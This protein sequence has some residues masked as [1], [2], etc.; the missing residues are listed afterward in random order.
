MLK[1]NYQGGAAVEEKK[2]MDSDFMRLDCEISWSLGL[3]REESVFTILAGL[4][5]QN[6]RSS[7]VDEAKRETINYDLKSLDPST[8]FYFLVS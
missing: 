2:G 7:W 1:K 8:L 5:K 6:E 4:T 3:R